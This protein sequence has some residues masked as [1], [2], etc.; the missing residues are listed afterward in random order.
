MP[1]EVAE[2][3]QNMKD[4]LGTFDAVDITFYFHDGGPSVV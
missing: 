4:C 1:L 2:N 3:W